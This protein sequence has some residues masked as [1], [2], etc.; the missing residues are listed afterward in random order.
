M[1]FIRTAEIEDETAIVAK[2]G[3]EQTRKL[4]KPIAV[5]ALVAVA[6]FF[7]PLES[8]RRTGEDEV[9]APVFQL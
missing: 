8:E 6:V 9:H 1:A 7:L 4:H 3:F 5:F 2:F